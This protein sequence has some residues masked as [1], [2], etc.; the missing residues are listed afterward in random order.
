[1]AKRAKLSVTCGTTLT[2]T[3]GSRVFG[4]GVTQR[5]RARGQISRP[6]WLPDALKG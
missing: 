3:T 4:V 5:G 6:F 1:M 2:K